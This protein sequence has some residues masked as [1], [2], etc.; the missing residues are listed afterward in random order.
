VRC[1]AKTAIAR[2]RRREARGTDASDAGPTIYA[3]SA[4]GFEPIEAS[5]AVHR[6][7]RTDAQTW[8]PGL[9][10]IAREIHARARR[11]PARP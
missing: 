11:A 9:R 2:L 5:A 6:V 1:A 4:A 7:L 10:R 8:R 3:Q